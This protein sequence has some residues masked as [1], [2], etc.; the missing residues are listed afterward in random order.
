MRRKRPRKRRIWLEVLI[1]FVVLLVLAAAACF[2]LGV[3]SVEDGSVRLLGSE[4][5]DNTGW[6]SSYEHFDGTR[7]TVLRGEGGQLFVGIE[8]SEGSLAVRVTGEG[9]AVLFDETFSGDASWVLDVPSRVTVTVRGEGHK[10]GFDVH[11][12]R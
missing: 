7:T 5:R 3:I 12:L 8:G 10:G 4:T 2:Q 1:V 9:G 6:Q 11:Y